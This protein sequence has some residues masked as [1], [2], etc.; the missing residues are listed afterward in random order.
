MPRSAIHLAVLLRDAELAT[1]LR[2]P[3]A[4]PISISTVRR[5]P[6]ISAAVYRVRAIPPPFVIVVVASVA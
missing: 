3:D 6:M 2:D 5:G 1:D 4:F